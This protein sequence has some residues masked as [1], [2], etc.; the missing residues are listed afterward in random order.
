M[1][2]RP[3]EDSSHRLA[4]RGDQGV[5]ILPQSVLLGCDALEQ[6]ECHQVEQRPGH[7]YKGETLRD[8]INRQLVNRPRPAFRQTGG[9]LDVQAAEHDVTQ[10]HGQSDEPGPERVGSLRV[11]V[12][13]M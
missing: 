5:L 1:R 7:R 12:H 2:Y 8:F 6:Q 3:C 13:T 11:L 4:V 10:R 9:P